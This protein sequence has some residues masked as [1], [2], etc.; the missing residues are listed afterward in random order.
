[1]TICCQDSS[2]DEDA[3]EYRLELPSHLLPAYTASPISAR[4]HFHDP[5]ELSLVI[6]QPVVPYDSVSDSA[7]FDVEDLDCSEFGS[8]FGFDHLQNRKPNGTANGHHP[9]SKKRIFREGE[10]TT[11]TLRHGH[12]TGSERGF[13]V[14]MLEP[15]QQGVITPATRMIVSTTP[16]TASIEDGAEINGGMSA[17][18]S[19]HVSLADFDADA[20]LS[21]SL[22]LSVSHGPQSHYGSSSMNGDDLVHSRSSDGSG[23]LTPRP[24]GT[25]SPV[26]NIDDVLADTGGAEGTRFMAVKAMGPSASDDEGSEVCWV[27]VAG[28]GRAGIFDGDWAFVKAASASDPSTSSGRLVRVIAWERLNDPGEILPDAPIT[29]SPPLHRA[30]FEGSTNSNEVFLAPTPFG[31][32]EPSLPKARSM[33]LARIATVEGVD[34]R[35]ERSWLRGVRRSFAGP[36][37]GKGKAAEEGKKLVRRGDIISVPVWQ[38]KPVTEVVSSSSSDEFDSDEGRTRNRHTQRTATGVAHFI[39]TALSYEPLV[40]FEEDFRSSISSKARAGELGC[41]VDFNDKGRTQVILNGVERVRIR[42]R[43]GDC[44]WHGIRM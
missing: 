38:E 6:L 31:A 14:L 10:T 32:R 17:D 1:M 44:A 37:K 25:V 22:A 4:I 34:K 23:S 21:S 7:V 30:L 2:T 15:V 13:K 8:E 41:W 40:P 20:F 18:G 11:F 33:T 29:I 42:G 43:N 24:T 39:V 16:H 3:D 35:Y 27:G 5:I 26:A 19:T 36:S 9:S 12:R 28:L